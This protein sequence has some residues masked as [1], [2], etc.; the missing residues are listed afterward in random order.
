MKMRE[1]SVIS[2]DQKTRGQ[3]Y[4]AIKTS[5]P[6][7]QVSPA[8]LLALAVCIDADHSTP[9]AALP[10]TL[11]QIDLSP[12]RAEL[13][14]FRQQLPGQNRY[15][16]PRPAS[17]PTRYYWVEATHTRLTPSGFEPFTGELAMVR[18]TLPD[19]VPATIQTCIGS[20]EPGDH[21]IDTVYEAN[22]KYARHLGFSL[23]RVDCITPPREGVRF[24]AV[25]VMLGYK[26]ASDPLPSCFILEAGT[27]T[28][29]PKV[30]YLGQDMSTTINAYSGYQPTPFAC[31]S[32]GYLGSL[33]MNGDNPQL[34]TISSREIQNG[35]SQQPYIRIEARFSLQTG[36]VQN[37]WPGFLIARAAALVLIRKLSGKIS[38]DCNPQLPGVVC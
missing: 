34:L 20:V 31:P 8:D 29:Q 19:T 6:D 4:Q 25:S 28:G 30:L 27:A 5:F 17:D 36:Q 15:T 18:V 21:L 37:I 7:S 32:H 11:S 1:D 24:G 35:Q 13:E 3:L 9:P 14:A 12:Y 2:F 16:V 10:P 33:T 38:E 26:R 23:A 22:Q